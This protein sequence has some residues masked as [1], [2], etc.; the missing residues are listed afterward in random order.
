VSTCPTCQTAY[1]P[2]TVVCP[3][4]GTSLSGDLGLLITAPGSPPP[5][6]KDAPDSLI[7]TS[8]VGRFNITRR[9][10]EG[11]MGMVYE[12]THAVIGRPVAIKVLHERHAERPELAGRL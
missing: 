1:P 10:G 4:D 2:E 6:A 12:A 11:G 9:I 3:A 7:G 8:L 5:K